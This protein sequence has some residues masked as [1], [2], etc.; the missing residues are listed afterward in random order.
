MSNFGKNEFGCRLLTL[1][2]GHWTL[3]SYNSLLA[4]TAKP[5]PGSPK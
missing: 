5:I 3:D 4:D 1:D 2:F